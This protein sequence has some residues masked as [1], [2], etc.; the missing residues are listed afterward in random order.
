MW[1]VQVYFRAPGGIRI[2]TDISICGNVNS[3]EVGFFEKIPMNRRSGN[4][5]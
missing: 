2:S 1:S 5:A 4:K 3:T